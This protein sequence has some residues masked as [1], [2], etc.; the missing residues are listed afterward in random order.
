LGNILGFSLW[1]REAILEESKSLERGQSSAMELIDFAIE[2]FGGCGLDI[3]RGGDDAA[4]GLFFR[5]AGELLGFDFDLGPVG[6]N[7]VIEESRFG[8]LGSNQAPFV[9]HEAIDEFAFGSRAGGGPDEPSSLDG[10]VRTT[11]G[12]RFG[13]G[14]RWLFLRRGRSDRG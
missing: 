8:G 2:S 12:I 10:R 1:E 5:R 7:L 13:A 11:R 4:P 14:S 9:G 6:S 3:E